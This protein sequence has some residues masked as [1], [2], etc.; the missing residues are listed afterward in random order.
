MLHDPDS[1]RV[2]LDLLDVA[3]NY[4]LRAYLTT[5]VVDAVAAGEVGA[6]WLSSVSIQETDAQITAAAVSQ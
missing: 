4:G 1:E 3:N 5:P 6:E 2:R